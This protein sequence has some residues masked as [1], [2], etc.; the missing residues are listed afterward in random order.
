MMMIDLRPDIE[1]VKSRFPDAKLLLDPDYR[2]YATHYIYSDE[3][4]YVGGAND[5]DGAWQ[6]ARCHTEALVNWE[7]RLARKV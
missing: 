5:V 6:N 4:G 2:A 1:I 7:T 3:W